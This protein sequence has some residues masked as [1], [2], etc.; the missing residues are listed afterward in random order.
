MPARAA[1]ERL[2]DH[3]AAAVVVAGLDQQPP[4]VGG[5][6]LVIDPRRR[7]LPVVCSEGTIPR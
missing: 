3:G 2:A 1:L 6:G 7:W 5:A 4:G